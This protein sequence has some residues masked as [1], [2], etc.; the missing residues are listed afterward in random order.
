M[1]EDPF[2]QVLR[3]VAQGRLTAEEAAPILDA[4]DRGAA[5]GTRAD[6]TAPSAEGWVE[7]PVSSGRTGRAGEARFARVEVREAGRTSVDLRIPLS[8]GRQALG[9]IPGLSSAQAA[10]IGEAVSRGLT[11]PIVDIQDEDGSGVRIVIE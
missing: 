3:L 8:L 11:G 10:E 5:A 2:G 4:L 9:I 7:P 1:A 6:G